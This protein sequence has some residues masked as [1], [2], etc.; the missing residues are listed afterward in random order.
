MQL[1]GD[2]KGE[3]M[4]FAQSPRFGRAITDVIVGAFPD[5]VVDDEAIFSAALESFVYTG[6]LPHGDNILE[7]FAERFSGADRALLLSWRDYVQGTFEIKE[8]YGADGVVA[9]NHVDELTYRIRSN[10]GAEGVERLTPGVVLVGGI[11]PVGGDW[12]MSGASMAFPAQDA[13][14]VCPE[15]G[16]CRCATRRRSSA[17][18]TSSHMLANSRPSSGTPSSTC[19][20]A[21]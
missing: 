20:E 6:R 8:P 13:D 10:M 15:Y 4:V 5:G 2:L 3:L 11:V 16:N 14:K 7:L 17:T 19:M 18:P 9:F 21:T 1:A 12:M